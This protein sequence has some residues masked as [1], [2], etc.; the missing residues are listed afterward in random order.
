[1][2]KCNNENE[3]MINGKCVEFKKLSTSW[4]IFGIFM[5][6]L[7]FIT[8]LFQVIDLEQYNITYVPYI[9]GA[10]LIIIGILFVR[11]NVES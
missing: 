3:I 8:I 5:F 10:V 7:G 9:I 6:A 4:I 2:K 1:M 11:S